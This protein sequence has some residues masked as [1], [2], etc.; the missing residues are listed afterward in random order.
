MKEEINFEGYFVSSE[1]DIAKYCVEKFGTSW[2]RKWEEPLVIEFVNSKVYVFSFGS[3]VFQNA[4]E[5]LKKEV[6]KELKKYLVEKKEKTNYEN[7]KL[8]VFDSKKEIEEFLKK[9]IGKDFFFV[10]EEGGVILKE[11]LSKKVVEMI[12]FV[13]AQAVA[14]RYIEEEVDN[15]VDSVEET[16]EKFRKS[17]LILST[18]RAVDYLFEVSS[19]KNR[20]IS[21]LMLLEAPEIT[22]EE[23]EL[24]RVYSQMRDYFDIKSSIRVVENK[25]SYISETSTYITSILAERRAEILEII[26]I[27]LII[28]EILLGIFR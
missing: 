28:V 17:I 11:K 27:V 22:W 25:L 2:K 18:K 26:I 23:E 10:T 7:F 16:L 4:D 14:L 20:I 1:I 9:Q 21:D 12:A 19:V 6:F 8:F 13:I 3:I 15:A 24:E 5:K